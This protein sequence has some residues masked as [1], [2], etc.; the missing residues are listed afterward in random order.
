MTGPLRDLDGASV[1]VTGASSGIG[2]A[3]AEQAGEMGAEVVLAARR[4]AKLSGVADRVADTGGRAHAVPA[5]VT[6][7]DAV[8]ALAET[9][10]ERTGG[11]DAVVVNAGT[12]EPRDAP[13]DAEEFDRVTRTN[14]D[15]AFHTA[16]ATLTPL[17]ESGGSLVFV[18][19]YLGKHPGAATPVYDASKW[20]LQG[21]ARSVAARHGAEVGVSVVNP[22]G[23][24]TEFGHD[25]RDRTNEERYAE[26]EVLSATQVAASVVFCLRQTPPA[27][28]AELDLFRRG[29]R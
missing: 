4:E 26:G 28:V 19:S 2:A 23:V 29:I 10:V 13:L 25:G 15:G 24:R 11:L 22:S 21:F 9:A 16:R 12:A 3:T 8:A 1:L 18:G 6:D 20:W 14:V 27:N 7:P 5:D 17:R